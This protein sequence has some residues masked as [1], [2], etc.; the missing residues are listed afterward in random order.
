[1][2]FLGIFVILSPAFD[3]RF[4]PDETAPATLQDEMVHAV[5]HFQSLL[6]IFSVHFIVL[7]GGDPVAHS[8]VFDRL[9]AEFAAASVVFAKGMEIPDDGD[10]SYFIS[11]FRKMVEGILLKSHQDI[12]SYYSRCLDL[13][14]KSFLWTGPKVEI[15]PRSDGVDSIIPSM[16]M[17]EVLDSPT[18]P[19]YVTDVDGDTDIEVLS[20]PTD[21]IQTK[22]ADQVGK[23][24]ARRDS[25]ELVDQH[26]LKKRRR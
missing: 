21:P 12:F 2:L 17:G 24:R 15:I 9:L 11:E 22:N 4:Y 19:I 5:N 23:R 3:I 7:I 20:Q 26:P 25:T 13:P 6:H 18:H 16:T 1:M 14:H 8:Y 10:R